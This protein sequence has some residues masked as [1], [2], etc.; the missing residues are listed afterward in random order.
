[1][2]D[3]HGDDIRRYAGI[4]I[5]FSSNVY[6]HFDHSELFQYL[7]SCLPRLRHYPEPEPHTLERRLAEAHGI[8]PDQVM[9]TAGATEAIY[10]I[11]QAFRGSRSSIITPTFAEYADACR[12]HQHDTASLASL[13]EVPS[14]AAM[15]WLCN[16][17]NPTGSVVPQEELATAIVN[18]PDTVF[19]LDA[20]YADYTAMPLI[21]PQ[22]ATRI[23]NLLTL[24]SMTKQYAIPGLRLGYIV[25]NGELLE[26]VR[27]QRMPWSVSQP[28]QDAGLFL[29]THS[30]HYRLPIDMLTRER[31]RMTLALAA[32]QGVEVH[33]SDCHIILCHLTNGKAP[34]L[35]EY[36]AC[37]HG[38]LI[39]DASNFTGLGSG[40]FRFAVQTPEED[41]ELLKA[42][43]QWFSI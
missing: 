41:D 39:R 36:L 37:G 10:L 30:S 7:A 17:N 32:M 11:A 8:S 3:G 28:A 12:L 16:P 27:S 34:E 35:K 15:V 14:D 23:P 33:K 20:S 40:H 6:G 5:N 29:L 1:M 18:H 26:R 9:A 25:A 38:L 42:I 43:K 2:T 4:R 31:E 13:D 19:V 24:H 21:S 22:E